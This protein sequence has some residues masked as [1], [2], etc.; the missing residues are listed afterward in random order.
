MNGRDDTTTFL[1]LDS[2][3]GGQKEKSLT[4]GQH[5]TRDQTRYIYKKVEMGEMIITDIIQQ[6]IEQEKQLSKIDDMNGEVNPYREL[7]VNN[8][9]RAEPLM[10]QMEQWSIL[11][12]ILYYVQHSRFNSMDHTL[13]VKAMNRYKI[14]PDMGREF[15]ELDFCITPQKLQEEYMD[16]YEG[17]HSDIVSSNI[18]DENSDISTT[19]L[20]RIE[21]KE[22]QDKLKAEES[23][24]ISESGYTLGRLLDG[25]RY[26]LLLDTGASKSFMSKSLYMQCKSLHT[27]PK[28]AS[29]TQRIQVRN[30]QCV[31]V[32]FIV[33]VIVDIHGH[34]FKIYILVS[35]IQENVDLVLGIKNIFKLEG[36]ISSRDCHFEFLNRSAPIY[37][38]KEI[39][40]KPDEQKLVKLKP[41]LLMKSQGWQ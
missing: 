6:E 22:G 38:E 2:R 5:L 13:D 35:E 20:G 21:N 36:V 18:F 12:N 3:I 25:T 39:I 31:S 14:K 16:I 7:I 8:V 27:L 1:L 26:Q 37:P 33:P 17:I 10:T 32:L 29:T 28:F 15:K 40:L 11:S 34:R 19:Y 24:P 9:E 23:F 30:S 4:V 41:H